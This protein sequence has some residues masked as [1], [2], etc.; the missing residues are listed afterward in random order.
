MLQN[1]NNLVRHLNACETMAHTTTICS[2]KT[3]TL[4]T[5]RMTVTQCFLNDEHLILDNN[6]KTE[7]V[8]STISNDLKNLIVEAIALNTSYTSKTLFL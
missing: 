5:G 7:Q 6:N 3:G 2:D 4:T 8:N 1:N